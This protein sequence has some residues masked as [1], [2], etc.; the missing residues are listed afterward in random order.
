MN[1]LALASR[2]SVARPS[3]TLAITARANRMKAEGIDV[4]SF[5]AG[6]PDF[7]TPDPICEAAIAAIRDGFTKYTASSG[8]AEL[9]EAIADKLWRENRVKVVPEQI[10][11][12][13]GAKHSLYNATQMLIEPG[14]EVILLAPFWMSY[15]DQVN[16]AGGI[17]V[18]VNCSP[19][20][21]FQPSADDIRRAV[22]PRTKAII[23]NSPCNP[24]GAVYSRQLIKEIAQIALRNGLWI[25][26]D[27]IYERLVYEG[28]EHVAMASLG[29]E[30]AD[31]TITI[32]GCSKSYSMTG[33]RL[34]FA[35]APLTVAKSMSN[36]Q[37]QVTS[38]PTSFVQKAAAHAFSMGPEL[39]EKMR[40]EFEAR[41][42]L[43]RVELGRING[44]PV[45]DPKGA[46]YLLLDVR[47]FLGGRL[48]T[49]QQLAETLLE[50]AQVALVPGSV[51]GASG[52]LRLSYTASQDNIC[53]GIARVGEVL[54]SLRS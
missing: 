6:E 4:I 49:D 52:F 40:I 13:C 43:A 37:D 5:G 23:V 25:I 27:E 21:G 1:T 29:A 3:P 51:F 32:G 36:F 17:P 34:G 28:T 22:T 30:V 33:W 26:C 18:I 24:T 14:D 45:P 11:A 47:A 48:A 41:R 54:N 53:R 2:A 9:K 10:I 12:S 31:H 50:Q 16:L 35:A 38:N 7:N 39:V 20:S 46:F 19:E 8:I 44:L 42:N 15:V